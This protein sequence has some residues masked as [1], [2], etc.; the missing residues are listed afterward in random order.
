MRKA[1]RGAA[2]AMKLEEVAIGAQSMERFLPLLGVERIKEAAAIAVHARK[3]LEGRVFWNVNSTAR[4]GGVAEMLHS[5]LAYVRGADI[6]ARWLVIGGSDDFFRI[7]KRLHHALHGS[8]GDGSPL[9]DEER[10]VYESVLQQNAEEMAGLVSPGDFVLLHDPQTAG[11]A[12]SLSNAGA[13]VIWRCHIGEE[14][15][16]PE[17]ERGWDFLEPYLD[18]VQAMIF[19][20]LQYVPDCCDH[21]K[22]V[23]IQPSIDAF[24][25]KNQDLDEPTV[26]AILVHSGLVEGPMGEGS[27]IFH[28]EDGSPARVDRHADVLR[29]GR[30]PTWDTPLVVQVSRWDPLKDPVGL[31][32]AFAHCVDGSGPAGAEL[33]LA[34]P[35]VRAIPDDPESAATFDEV[36]AAWRRL[37]HGDRNR[38]HLACL[39][40]A[41]VEENAAIVNA[42]QRHAAVVVQKS[43]REGFGLTVTEAMWKSRPIVASAV[44]GIQDQIENGVHGLL[45]AD[46]NDLEACGRAL[47]RML[48]D[49]E[50][51]QRMGRAA[52]ERVKENYLG[53][54]HLTQYAE[55]IDRFD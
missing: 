5:L 41:D 24:S 10:A 49:P 22:S 29:L 44:G 8:P 31:L 3:K 36:E 55:L 45:I 14:Q 20:R 40:M 54:R 39:P 32:Q 12:P 17:V 13:N 43:V 47:R 7:T 30:A 37:S 19:S 33:I 9:G 1:R 42:L 48:D 25:A 16:D 53:L 28:R 18:A 4:G 11:L 46:P 2:R 34:G 52:H 50:A 38:I 51:A 15:P 6:D 35:N 26:R 27:P 21:G 23:I